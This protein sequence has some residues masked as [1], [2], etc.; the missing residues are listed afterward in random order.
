MATATSPLEPAPISPMGRLTGVFFSPK[1][2]FADIARRP[3]WIL[4][5]VLLSIL[6]LGVAYTM[7]K[8]IDWESYLRSQ[9]EK[10]P[11]FANLTEA[12]AEQALAPQVKW[13][14]RTV[15][16]FGPLRNVCIVLVVSLIY[17]GALASSGVRFNQSFAITAF[18][19]M[20]HVIASILVIITLSLRAYGESTPEN[21]LPS[22]LGAFMSSDAPRWQTSLGTSVELFDLYSNFLAALGLTMVNPKKISLTKAL[23]VVFGAWLLWV[24]IKVGGAAAFS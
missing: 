20:P 9:A 14:P 23:V 11:R 7:N 21:M 24:L 19:Q 22:H 17:W 12:Q 13:T 10:S 2:T 15:Y 5:I 8:K 3:S 16:V 4:P 1:E 18:A 6:G